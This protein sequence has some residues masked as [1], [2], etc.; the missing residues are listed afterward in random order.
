M[1][2]T[3]H[4]K[5]GMFYR[6]GTRELAIR[7]DCKSIAQWLDV[8]PDDKCLDL[9]AHIGWF[10]NECVLRGASV[11]CVEADPINHKILQRNA[12]V[13]DNASVKT[14]NAAIVADSY[15]E[16]TV[17]FYRI[18][19]LQTGNGSILVKTR[20]QPVEEI[21]VPVIKFRVALL[22]QE[23]TLL[24]ID[25]EGTELFLDFT[26]IPQSISRIALELH[27]KNRA[28]LANQNRVLD[29]IFSQGFDVEESDFRPLSDQWI[30][31]R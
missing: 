10:M 8:Q 6:D 15:D 20:T 2:L 25:V 11:V 19:R 29:E 18:K 21:I 12:L 30:F 24:K 22:Q 13:H 9:G 27:A 14:V 23:F 5:T 16:D 1:N 4:K 26:N 31:K 17:I 7:S 3:Q 28:S